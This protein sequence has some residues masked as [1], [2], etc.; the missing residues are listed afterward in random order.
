MINLTRGVLSRFHH[1]RLSNEF[2]QDVTMWKTLLKW[3]GRS[4]FLD[5]FVTSSPDLELYT[6]AATTVGF[7]G[8]F[9]GKWF[10]GHWQP[11]FSLTRGQGLVL[12]GRNPSLLLL[13]ALYGTTML[14]GNAFSFGAI[15]KA[16]SPLS[17]QVTPK[18]PR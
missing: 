11:T 1:I 12:N 9:N 4:F 2:R 10:Q 16:L 14:P 3:N 13:P 5:S 8:Y 7:T 17:T 15:M 6:D 18:L